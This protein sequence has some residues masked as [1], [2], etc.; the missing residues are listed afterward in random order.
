LNLSFP[1]VDDEKLKEL[2]AARTI[3]ERSE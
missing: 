1:K 3:L 2:A